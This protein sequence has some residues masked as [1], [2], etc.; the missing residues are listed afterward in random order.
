H[1]ARQRCQ[2][3]GGDLVSLETPAECQWVYPFAAAQYGAPETFAFWLG[4]TDLGHENV[5]AWVSGAPLQFT[6]WDNGEPDNDTNQDVV[7]ATRV[8][9]GGLQFKW[10]DTSSGGKQ[11]FVCEWER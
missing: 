11:V 10:Q 6:D 1:Q 5:F 9:A 3:L 8:A 2:E 4:A 7:M